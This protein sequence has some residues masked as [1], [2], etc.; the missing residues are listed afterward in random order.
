MIIQFR[1]FRNWQRSV[2]QVSSKEKEVIMETA[3]LLGLVSISVFI[4]PSCGGTT[5][6]A[7]PGESQYSQYEGPGV[8]HRCTDLSAV[9]TQ[10]IEA[11]Q[12]GTRLHYAHTSH[13]GQLTEG[14]QS[15][16]DDDSF[17]SV[18][19]GYSTLPAESG[20]LC[21]FDGQMDETYVGPELFWETPEGMDMTRAV[22]DGNPQINVCMWCWCTQLDWYGAEEVE[23]YL[24]AMSTLE[25]EY[26]GVTFVYMTGNAQ[27]QGSEGYNR[28]QRNSQIRQF[29]EENGR[30]LF[31][32]ADMD[33]WYNGEQNTY[34]YQEMAIPS[35]HPHY[36][37]DEAGHTTYESCENK[38]SALWWLLALIEGWNG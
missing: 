10:W 36:Y 18:A 20:A 34:N 31:D 21:I 4:L 9:P 23:N 19:I 12:N 7:G 1:V 26:P 38:G 28:F 11:V 16:E 6:P 30:Y 25:N 13:G 14:L 5:N 2:S 32:F 17:Y 27:S 15:I 3:A 29:C 37:G 35:E 22:L 8:D 24:D 33:C